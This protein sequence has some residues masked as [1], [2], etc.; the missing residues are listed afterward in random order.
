MELKASVAYEITKSEKEYAFPFDYI[1]KEFV[2]ARILQGEEQTALTFG[3][4]YAIEKNKILLK[5]APPTGAV[6]S[7]YRETPTERILQWE[8]GSILLARDMSLSDLQTLHILEEQRDRLESSI[9]FVEDYIKQIAG[10][11]DTDLNTRLDDI[12]STLLSATIRKAV[13]AVGGTF[14]VPKGVTKLYISA[15]GAGAGGQAGEAIFYE[16]YTVTPGSGLTLTI[17]AGGTAGK[18][19]GNTIIGSL[20][21]LKGGTGTTSSSTG[22]SSLYGHGG[23]TGMD[24]VGFGAGGGAGANGTNGIIV[25]EW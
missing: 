10:D 14:A 2:K 4:H 12:T 24:G 5:A 17:G 23:I 7:I 25:I 21:T 19:G 1:K 18:N 6:L 8:D 22:G 15:C 9:Q 11:L 20:R 13:Y 3:D 16:P